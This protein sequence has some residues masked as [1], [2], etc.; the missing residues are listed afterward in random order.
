MV[1]RPSNADL[2]TRLQTVIE[3]PQNKELECREYLKYVDNLLIRTFP[4]TVMY[5]STEYRGHKGDTDYIISA[6]IRDESGFDCVQAYIWELKAPQCYI[7]QKDT[8]NRLIPSHELISAENQLMNYHYELQ[9]DDQFRRKAKVLHPHQVRL[10]GIIIGSSSTLVRGY[11]DKER[12]AE[13]YEEALSIRKHYFYEHNGI[14]LV[15]WDTILRQF[16]VETHSNEV[17]TGEFN[18]PVPACI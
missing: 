4:V 2:Y 1:K 10:G 13:L 8:M 16:S 5:N 18:D 6:N 14:R 12:I 7:F 3:S 17:Y 9:G 11:K 15:T